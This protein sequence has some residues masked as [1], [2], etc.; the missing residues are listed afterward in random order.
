MRKFRVKSRSKNNNY[1]MV[2][3]SNN[4]SINCNCPSGI[5]NQ[6]CNHI[7]LVLNFVNRKPVDAIEYDRLE[8]VK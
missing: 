7:E 1:Y 4:G 5:L 3:L 6:A 2:E 8:E